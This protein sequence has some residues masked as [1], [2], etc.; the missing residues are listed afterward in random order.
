MRSLIGRREL[1]CAWMLAF[2]ALAVLLLSSITLA[3]NQA[4]VVN[5]GVDQAIAPV[6]ATA[7]LDAT[8]TDDGLPNPPAAFTVLWT[9][10]SGPGNVTFGNATAVDT[11]ATFSAAGTYVLRLTAAD[12]VLQAYDQVTIGVS[13]RTALPAKIEAEDYR[14]G[15]EGIAYHDTKKGNSGRQYRSDNVDIYACADTGGGYCVSAIAAG[16]WLAYDV[17]VPVTDNYAITFRVADKK[18]SQQLHVMLDN[19]NVT[20]TVQ[21]DTGGLNNWQDVTAQNVQLT[22]G[23]HVLKVVFDASKSSN[24]INYIKVTHGNAAPVVNAGYDDQI[25]LPNNATLDATV[26]DDGW[27]N[28]PGNVTTLWTKLSGPGTVTFGNANAVDTTAAF[29]AAGAYVLRLTATDSALQAYDEVTITVNSDQQNQAP[30]VNAGVDQAIVLPNN[31]TLDATV[32]DDGKPNPPGTYTVL[33]TKQSGPGTVTFGNA[34]VV[35]TTATFGAAGTYVLRLTADDDA[36]TAY[37]ELTVT[38]VVLAEG[39]VILPAKIQAEDYRTGGEGVGYHD[40]SSGNYG[41]QYRSDDVDIYT[42]SDTGGGYEVRNIVADEWLAFNVFVP[43]TSKYT[44]TLRMSTGGSQMPFHVMMD[45]TNVTGAVTSTPLSGYQDTVTNDV[46][47][48]AGTHVM[49]IAFDATYSYTYALNYIDIAGSTPPTVDVGSDLTITLPANSVSLDATVT[50]DGLPDPPG[51]FTVRWTVSSGP[52]YGIVT[53]GDKNA[54]DTTATF[55]TPGV[56]VLRLTADD[57]IATGCDELTITVNDVSVRVDLPG[58]LEAEDYSDQGEGVSY[59]DTTSGNSG[60]V[61]R[62]DGVDIEA[63]GDTGGGYDVG[64][65]VAGEWLAFDVEVSETRCYDIVARVT[66]ATSSR[67]MHVE[68]DGE[69]VTGAMAFDSTGGWTNV[70]AQGVHLTAGKHVVKVVMDTGDFKLN[71]VDVLNE[72]YEKYIV[73]DG[74]AKADIVI[75]GNPPRSVTLAANELRSIIQQITGATLPIVTAPTGAEV[76]IYVGQSSYTDTLGVTA[77]GL[78]YDA[79][80]MASGSNWLVLIGRDTDYQEPNPSTEAGWDAVT[81]EHWGF[82]PSSTGVSYTYQYNSELN[83]WQGDGSGSLQAVYAFLYDLG[84]RWYFPGE[85][86]EVIPD[87]DDIGLPAVNR[88]VEPDFGFRQFFQYYNEFIRGGADEVKWQLRLGLNNGEE[89][90]GPMRGHGINLVHERDEVKQAHPEWFALWN[91]VRQTD[92]MGAGAPCLSAQG[93][94]D[95]NVSFI[96]AVFDIYD[97]PSVNIT[98]NDGYATLCECPLCEGKST[99]DRGWSGLLSDYVFDY[100]NYV[101][102]EVYKTHPDKMV[103][104]LAYTTYYLPPEKIAQMSPNVAIVFCRWRSWFTD[105]AEEQKYN[106]AIAAWKAKLP[107]GKVFIWDYYLHARPPGNTYT[108]IPVYF[109]AIIR[110][111]L[112]SL[113]GVSGG[114]FIEVQRNWPAW[115]LPYHALAT[116]HLNC[117][118]T[119]RLYWDANQDVGAMLEEY[120]VKFYGPAASQMKTFVEYCEQNWP[121]APGNPSIIAQMRTRLNAAI[122]A[123]AGTGIYADRIALVDDF[124]AAAEE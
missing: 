81:G 101:A 29:S 38:V 110:R 72:T 13:A 23:D 108:G 86:G 22:S 124:L 39:T 25:T 106:D 120:Y 107:S 52:S 93:L 61:Y 79:F 122:A 30:V 41:G 85:I 123:A 60:G 98:P 56:Y 55:D 20:G 57:S 54:I 119:A 11:T 96:R 118:L 103:T 67:Q 113:K 37:D 8:V 3:K 36:L 84:C 59:H 50:D 65:I 14:Y 43:C 75:S 71:Y 58:R 9:K 112:R 5:A 76:H 46:Q 21:Y 87:L 18:K 111:D 88:T 90:M 74:V 27:P 47:L 94:R 70:I 19:T 68:V 4:A 99:P 116:N 26:S 1:P 48:T 7:T 73:E 89:V 35:D 100:V 109:M 6:S 105:P 64:W 24:S 17:S 2:V 28:Y 51:A 114:D 117:Y 10:Q 49:K 16:E 32:T 121:N 42:C 115:N 63:C 31:A 34:T 15:G 45:T 53:F 92:Y 12:S 91:G 80:K 44:F 40:T 33:W 83:I 97:P 78:K 77:A 82:P 62:S 66:S 102:S 69:D 95:S 104:A